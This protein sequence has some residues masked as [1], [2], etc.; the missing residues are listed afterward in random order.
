MTERRGFA[1]DNHA[2]VHPE[3]IEAIAA[4]NEGHAAAY[5]GDPVDG[6][7]AAALPRA[8]RAG[9]AGV[10]GLQRDR[11]QRAL[12]G[13]AH[14]SV[15][16]RRLRAHRAPARRR[17]RRAGARRAQAADRRHA[18]RPADARAGRAAAGAD[19]RRARRPAAAD[20]DHPEHRARHR[21]PAGGGRRAGRV[22]AR[23]RDAAARRR[24]PAVQR[25]RRARR[26]AAR[27]D[28]RRRRRRRLLRRHQERPD[29][30]RGRRP[31]ARRHR[32]RLQV[33]P[34]AGD[35]ARV[36]DALHL[37]AARG[38]AGRRPVG[39]LGRARQRDGP[40]AGRR[41]ARPAGRA[42]HPAGRGQRGVRGARPG[43]SPSGSSRAGRSTSGTRAPA[44]CAGWR[45]GTPTEEEVDAF[46]AD[47][48]AA[49]S[50]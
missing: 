20:L 41:R 1:S 23:A 3:V 46:A 34:Q 16:G 31:A 30:R 7:R 26:P 12:P 39:A 11:G 33:P 36:E 22:G 27:P 10:P 35:A 24:R 28:H 40:P 18:R 15:A 29:G 13:G 6:A 19:R 32:R 49:L 48:R 47:V 43:R 2:G 38:A 4:A 17:V 25:R 44:R 50:S 21:L 9:G 42:R 8:L 37:G 14:P 45:R 5:G